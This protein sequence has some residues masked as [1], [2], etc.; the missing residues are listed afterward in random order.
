MQSIN[1]VFTTI[2]KENKE[3]MNNAINS[4]LRK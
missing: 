1:D 3:E 2:I 4:I